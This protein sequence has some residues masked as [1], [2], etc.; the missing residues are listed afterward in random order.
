MGVTNLRKVVAQQC[1]T[2]SQTC[3]FSIITPT[4]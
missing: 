3:D 1:P 2:G 4:R